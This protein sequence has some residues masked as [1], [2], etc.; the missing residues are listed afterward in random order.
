MSYQV[1]A[2]K[3]RPQRFADVLGQKH[4]T[5]TLQNAIEKDRVGHGYL[6]V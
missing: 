4:I 1:L 5:R 6:F 2:R 3:W